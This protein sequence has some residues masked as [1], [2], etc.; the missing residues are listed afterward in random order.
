MNSLEPRVVLSGIAP[1]L[2]VYAQ[3]DSS[4]FGDPVTFVAD[5]DSDEGRPSTAGGTVT[6]F[7]GSAVL[8][9]AKV[10]SDFASITTTTLSA[11]THQ[12]T[13]QFDLGD[14]H[15]ISANTA[16]ELVRYPTGFGFYYNGSN[17]QPTPDGVDVSYDFY[18]YSKSP[19]S[20]RTIPTGNIIVTDGS[21]IVAAVPWTSRDGSS[22]KLDFHVGGGSHSIALSYSGDGLFAPSQSAFDKFTIFPQ[23]IPTTRFVAH[24]GTVAY[25]QPTTFSFDLQLPPSSSL[26]PSGEFVIYDFGRPIAAEPFNGT[27][28]TFTT[29]LL[30]PGTHILSAAYDGPEFTFAAYE[31]T[32]TVVP[33]N[34]AVQ[35]APVA[36]QVLGEQVT[37]VATV[38]S[39]AGIPT[40]HVQFLD[41][42]T[43]LGDAVLSGG[44]AL[45]TLPATGAGQTH[46]IHAVYEGAGYYAKSQSPVQTV[47]TAKASP[48]ISFVTQVYGVHGNKVSLVAVIAPAYVGAPVPTGKFTFTAK[49][50]VIGVAR[51]VA[52]AAELIVPRSVVIN[53]RVSVRYVGDSNYNPGTSNLSVALKAT[54]AHA[55]SRKH[56]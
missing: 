42:S 44:K 32:Q 13:A 52:G 46:Q 1:L 25:G 38:S 22:Q 20:G 41:G 49:G 51:M 40:G 10:S 48:A 31:I 7:D 45:L 2:S 3:T 43:V 5:L 35:L 15:R 8:G 50:H 55:V 23:E 39:A 19:D 28:I 17:L 26:A 27:H 21:T 14:D 37:Y 56:A 53:K 33:A 54:P 30:A 9:T 4:I 11:G 24:Q 34:T 36:Q 12:I 6:F 47:F 29:P 18:V 16:T